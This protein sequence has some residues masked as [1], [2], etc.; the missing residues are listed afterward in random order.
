LL[1]AIVDGNVEQ[2]IYY[3]N[4]IRRDRVGSTC[5][6]NPIRG[7]L[8]FGTWV[9]GPPKFQDFLFGGRGEFPP[10]IVTNQD[11][12]S[13]AHLFPREGIEMTSPTAPSSD[14]LFLYSRLCA[15][16][17]TSLIFMRQTQ[18]VLALVLTEADARSYMF[19]TVS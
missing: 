9:A 4:Y 18:P 11:I 10:S 16:S 1:M 7:V 8:G 15:L 19:I 2:K 12:I 5:E 13:Y 6:K 14:H 17:L 3:N